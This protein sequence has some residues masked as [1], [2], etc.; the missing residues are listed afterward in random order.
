MQQIGRNV[1]KDKPPERPK[2]YLL[3]KIL[4]KYYEFRI[5]LIG[6]RIKKYG[7]YSAGYRYELFQANVYHKQA[8]LHKVESRYKK[9]EFR[10]SRKEWSKDGIR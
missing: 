3:S 4:I 7:R 10:R 2:L 6:K 1:I 8:Y 5:Y 9:D